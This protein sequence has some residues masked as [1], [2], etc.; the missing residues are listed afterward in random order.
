MKQLTPEEFRDNYKNWAKTAPA[1]DSDI[2]PDSP[3]VKASP[4]HAGM[5][6]DLK[7]MLAW[8]E[9]K[10]HKDP[11]ATNF[12][13]TGEDDD[14]FL[15]DGSKER[16]VR[17]PDSEWEIRP[18]IQEMIQL[19]SSVKFEI[20]PDGR[21]VPVG[22][23]IEYGPAYASP[24]FGNLKPVMRLGGLWFN[25]GGDNDCR[26]G[27]LMFW[28]AGA[29]WANPIDQI[30]TPK[31]TRR[32]PPPDA[33]RYDQEECLATQQENEFANDNLSPVDTQILNLSIISQS[34]K[35]V[36]EHLGY[37]AKTAE[38]QGKRMTLK[39]VKSF[40]ELKEKLAA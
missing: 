7:A 6:D 2:I 19:I 35:G 5:C 4:R 30:G 17:G 33:Q 15:A 22:G 25:V 18:T 26:S 32:P 12:L 40:A 13:Q 37:R 23:D 24:L 34:F 39:A 9:L 38:R 21:K 16:V 29:K 3:R 1:R 28:K 20:R 10:T 8:R 14:V 27:S 36:G 31:Q 11:L